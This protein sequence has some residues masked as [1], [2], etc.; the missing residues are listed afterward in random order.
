MKNLVI[1][2][3]L[4]GLSLGLSLQPVVASDDPAELYGR[5]CGICHVAAGQPT[6]APPAFGMKNHVIRQH[7]D[8]DSF[9]DYVVNWVAAPNPETALMPGAV[10][11]FGVMPILPYPEKQ[12]RAIAE[13]LYDADL[14]E[15][16]WYNAHYQ[17]EHGAN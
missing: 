4:F 6:V 7:P 12:V 2:V 13:F 14:N 3:G 8:K 15:P 11:R 17:A 5:L 10:R 16:D 9:V 1:G